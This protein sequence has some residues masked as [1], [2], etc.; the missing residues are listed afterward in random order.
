[1]RAGTLMRGGEQI[2]SILRYEPLLASKCGSVMRCCYADERL[3]VIRGVSE[4]LDSER[5]DVYWILCD[6]NRRV[7][8]AAHPP[9]HNPA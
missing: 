7:S 9:S 5:G 8:A 4:S 1:M 2:K 6:H 3:F